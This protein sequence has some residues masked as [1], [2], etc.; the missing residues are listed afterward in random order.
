VLVMHI[1]AEEE[2]RFPFEDFTR[3]TDLEL[4]QEE[5]ALDPMT[6]RTSYLERV[7]KFMNDVQAGCGQMEIDYVPFNT[8]SS[9][10]E[11]LAQYLS[12]RRT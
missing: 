4:I 5:L 3:F 12:R 8:K 7:R 2:L 11:A 6:I 10:D 9:F 1:M